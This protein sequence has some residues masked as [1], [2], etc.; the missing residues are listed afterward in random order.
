MSRTSIDKQGPALSAPHLARKAPTA[1][2]YPMSNAS[3]VAG[4]ALAGAG[5]GLHPEEVLALQRACGNGAVQ[6]MLAGRPASPPQPVSAPAPGV[7]QR[8]V[9]DDL[10]AAADAY[11]EARAYEARVYPA[12]GRYADKIKDSDAA[13]DVD[14]QDLAER[15]ARGLK[16]WSVNYYNKTQA[17]LYEA[18][19][20]D[21]HT[22]HGDYAI[23]GVDTSFNPDLEVHSQTGPDPSWSSAAVEFKASTSS[24]YY[25]VRKL[26][27]EGLAQLGKREG[28]RNSYGAEFD[29]LLLTVHND[30]PANSF[31]FTR[32]KVKKAYGGDPDDIPGDDWNVQL[33]AVLAPLVAATGIR[34]YVEVRMEQQG[35]RYATAVFNDQPAPAS[36]SGSSSDDMSD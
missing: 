15:M 33:E 4:R 30:N 34:T 20:A 31:P 35:R 25:A 18:Q 28:D 12:L 5:R 32:D 24:D 2:S 11:H 29:R 14:V 17:Y 16:T 22:R 10:E 36:S 27:K 6:R 9:D 19:K 21:D 23:L 3:A 1:S 26:V 7:V 8:A 13:G